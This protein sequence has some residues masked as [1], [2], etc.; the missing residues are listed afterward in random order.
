VS[1]NRLQINK[2]QHEIWDIW[3]PH[4]EVEYNDSMLF[5][6]MMI[7]FIIIFINVCRVKM[8]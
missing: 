2:E 3:D 8:V 7:I 5:M 6:I 4:F 1:L